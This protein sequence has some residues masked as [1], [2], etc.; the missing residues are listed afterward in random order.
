MLPLGGF[1]YGEN[2]LFLA[3][4]W[5]AGLVP[6]YVIKSLNIW[7]FLFMCITLFTLLMLL[8]KVHQ[9]LFFANSESS[10]VLWFRLLAAKYRPYGVYKDARSIVVIH[11]LAHQVRCFSWFSIDSSTMTI[12]PFCLEVM[13]DYCR[14]LSLHQPT[15]ILDC[16]QSGMEH[17]GGYFLL[18]QEHMLL[19][20]VKL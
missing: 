17:W 2:C 15:V 6:V 9:F 16:P 12:L 13:V 1:T 7:W 11:N 18:G 8:L 14:E 3:N 4:D 20:L 19:T 10:L 5:H